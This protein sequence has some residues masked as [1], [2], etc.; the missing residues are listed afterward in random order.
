MELPWYVARVDYTDTAEA[1]RRARTLPGEV[2]DVWRSSVEALRIPQPKT[3]LD[4]G[5]GPGGFLGPL[6]DWFH[7]PV[8]AIEPSASMRATA[9][10]VGLTVRFPYIAGRAEALPL[11][12]ETIDVA[13]LSTVIHQFD[14]RDRA[15]RELRRVTRPGGRVLVRGFFSD[16]PVT[17]LLSAFPGIARSAGSFP[18]TPEIVECLEAAGFGVEPPE[19]VVEP[20]Q[21][22]LESW[23]NRVK[24]IRHTDSA[25]RPLTDSEFEEGLR[26]VRSSHSSSE[27]IVSDGTLRLVVAIA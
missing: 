1:Y 17:G 12:R 3:V 27:R 7:A 20:W 25:L 10:D 4:L 13:W 16:V 24:S 5:A 2:L 9:T 8:V 18:S 22:E 15:A 19:N 6:E 23:V 11:G 21:F 26:V 14:D